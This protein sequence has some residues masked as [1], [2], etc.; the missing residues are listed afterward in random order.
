MGKI[1]RKEIQKNKMKLSK[2]KKQ[3][4]EWMVCSIWTGY[5]DYF[6]SITKNK[7]GKYRVQVGDAKM[8][9]SA[10]QLISE[11]DNLPKEDQNQIIEIYNDIERDVKQYA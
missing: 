3:K 10:S 9:Y 1:I 7:N 4:L 5:W 2:E 11:W 8:Y 6:S